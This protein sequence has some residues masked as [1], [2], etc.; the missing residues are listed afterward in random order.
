MLRHG[1]IMA[2]TAIEPASRLSPA[3][4][5][6]VAAVGPTNV[7]LRTSYP[8][9]LR[10]AGF[11]DVLVDDVTAAYRSTLAAWYEETL[12]RADAVADLVG[13]DEFEE[14]QHRRAG[15]LAAID[16]GSL[17]RS[18]YIARRTRDTSGP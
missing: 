8:S 4:R 2:F 3:E 13:P 16:A 5:R 9:L 15:A 17:R 11:V 6:H 12:R 10:S 7:L 18:R 14:R 1:G